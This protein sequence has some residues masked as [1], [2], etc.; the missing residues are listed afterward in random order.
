[1]FAP[2]IKENEFEFENPDT[3][4]NVTLQG[5]TDENEIFIDNNNVEGIHS[6]VS[7]VGETDNNDFSFE[8]S[9]VNAEAWYFLTIGSISGTL[10][11]LEKEPI[12]T[13]GR[14]KIL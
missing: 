1:M 14:K 3:Q 7:L 6:T 2:K 13:L 10:G 5:R 12:G 9:T 8:N 4:V 11:T